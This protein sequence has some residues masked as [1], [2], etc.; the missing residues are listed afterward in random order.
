M[1]TLRFGDREKLVRK[2]SFL[3]AQVCWTNILSLVHA[4]KA[5]RWWREDVL[6]KREGKSGLVNQGASVRWSVSRKTLSRLIHLLQVTP[7]C[8]W[9]DLWPEKEK[10]RISGSGR[11][12]HVEKISL[13]FVTKI[14]LQNCLFF[15]LAQA[16]FKTMLV[17]LS[18]R[19]LS[20]LLDLNGL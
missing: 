10:K 7:S 12:S 19:A 16:C 18:A 4:G 13:A 9:L 3:E 2:Q 6:E 20:Q 1:A 11:L 8:H 14:N 5:S 17:A 15:L